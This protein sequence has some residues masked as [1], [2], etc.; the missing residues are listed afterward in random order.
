LRL[1]GVLA[2]AATACFVLTASASAG[3]VGWNEAAKSKG[4]SVMTYTVDTLT[5]NAKGWS[6]HVSFH[7]VSH[8]TIGVR[9][10]F[11]VA[12]F[13]NPTTENLSKEIGWAAATT[14][15]T[16]LPTS[17]KPGD[18]WTGT[19]GGDGKLT[20]KEKVWARV[21]FGPFSSLPGQTMPVVWITDHSLPLGKAPSQAPA[22]VQPVG[23]VI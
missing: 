8:V 19:I 15:S 13:A 22:P 2:V 14:F 17:L 9:S 5:F 18:S 1:S 16:K 21:V 3:R 7:N 12:F 20:I 23:P 10:E 11:G 4:K 6:A